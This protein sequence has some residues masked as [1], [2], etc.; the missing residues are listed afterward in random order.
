MPDLL[1]RF[2]VLRWTKTL[3]RFRPGPRALGLLVLVLLMLVRAS[4]PAPLRYLR[5]RTFDLYQSIQPRERVSTPVVIVD[6]DEDSLA[7]LGQWP[8]P[9]TL[10]ASLVD[11]LFEGGAAMVAFDVV[12]PEPDRA[13]P[14]EVADALPDLD[15]RTAE[16][17]RQLPSNS[18]RFARAMGGGPVVLGQGILAQG[19]TAALVRPQ[20]PSMALIGEDP[21]AWMPRFGPVLGNLP[22]LDRAASGRGVFVLE[23]ED[24]GVV[25]RVPMVLNADGIL[26]P[27]LSTEILRLATGNET[28]GIRARGNPTTDTDALGIEGLVLRPHFIPT[29]ATGRLWVHFARHDP[30]LFVPARDILE[31]RVDPRRLRGRIALVGTSAVGLLDIKTT[32][33]GGAM[34]G[35]EVHAQ[36]IETVV[37][38]TALR[39]SR[40]ADALEIMLT[41]G[42]GMVLI[43]LVPLI[44][45]S[46]TLVLLVA[47]VGAM[48]GASWLAFSR[49][50]TL[51]DPVFPAVVAIVLHILL[52]YA[53]H[54]RVESQRRQIRSAFSHYMAPALVKRLAEDPG[55]LRLGGET[56]NLTL[57][58]CDIRGFSA[59]SESLD[60]QGV[61]RLMNRFLTPMTEV[62]LAH[63]GTIDKYIGDCIMAFWNAPLDDPDHAG[64]AARAALAMTVRLEALNAELA[65]EA[66]ADGRRVECIRVGIGLNTGAVCVGNV[67]SDQRFDYSVLG[68][69]VNLASRLEELTK[70]YG[71]TI[72]IGEATARALEG[73]A[74]IP[75]DVVPVRGRAGM[76]RLF[77][78][79]GDA[80][81]AA[82]PLVR[83]LVEAQTVLMDALVAGD[84]AAARH[85]LAEA[86]SRARAAGL[87]LTTA[88]DVVARRLDTPRSVTEIALP[89]PGLDS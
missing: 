2:A 25:R 59:L 88:H 57:M 46:W 21:R 32:P 69:D 22:V 56:R 31:G 76:V 26:W 44:G 36:V 78:L 1:S 86:R 45:A 50:L 15:P 6:I 65:A 85:A 83:A 23:G 53:S 27:A 24:D 80:A 71:V 13:S 16:R 48:F 66:T 19:A 89:A 41:L 9:R 47:G 40:F 43:A 87:G 52:S 30:S 37:D 12:F 62:I 42:G 4:D 67:G 72:V 7:H 73:M 17:L 60:A 11:A 75:L 28:I 74:A 29:D 33:V 63:G 49:G 38:G 55:R 64:N 14:G 61:T 35:V 34:P 51:I 84:T 20:P 77:G 58:F 79:F 82:R 5:T 18:E 68:D 39:R 54:M 70:D 10:L 3:W 8:W 81:V